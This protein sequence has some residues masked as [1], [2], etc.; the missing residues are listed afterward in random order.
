MVGELL[1]KVAIVI[2]VV[3]MA[4]VGIVSPIVAVLLGTIGVVASFVRDAN[5]KQRGIVRRLP[6]LGWVWVLALV[7]A[8]LLMAAVRLL[9]GQK[10][11]ETPA[12][13]MLAGLVS[14]GV[15]AI[16]IGVDGFVAWIFTIFGPLIDRV[17]ALLFGTSLARNDQVALRETQEYRTA[18]AEP[19]Y[20]SFV[21]P[22]HWR[23]QCPRCGARV[24][25][26]IDVCW[27]CGYG[28]TAINSPVT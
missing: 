26:K 25:Y 7:V 20:S 22:P 11:L 17:L 2:T 8:G 15:R 4:I 16:C 24:E 6:A 23:Y 3:M 18:I 14:I 19:D 5:L 9:A 10:V 1:S 27:N 21:P 28:S 13:I 12:I